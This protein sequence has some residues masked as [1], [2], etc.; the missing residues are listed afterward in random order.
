MEKVTFA[1]LAITNQTFAETTSPD[2]NLLNF[3]GI[4][5]DGIFGMAFPAVANSRSLPP[6]YNMFLQGLLAAP[7]F[8]F[9]FNALVHSAY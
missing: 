5:I 9:Y 8:S 7:V 6:F 3:G 4:I 1:G 2:F